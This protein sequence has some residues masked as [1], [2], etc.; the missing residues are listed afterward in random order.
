MG[1]M[2]LSAAIK[3]G[4]CSIDKDT[5]S[6]YDVMGPIHGSKAALF[7]KEICG[8]LIMALSCHTLLRSES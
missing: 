1:T 7:L 6:W 2:I 5:V 8:K 3:N 4:V